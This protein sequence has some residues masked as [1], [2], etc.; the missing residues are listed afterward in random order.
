VSL[1]ADRIP[2][3]ISSYLLLPF[4]LLGPAIV[5]LVFARG[6]EPTP[7]GVGIVA[8]AG[9]LLALREGGAFALLLLAFPFGPKFAFGP[10]NLYLATVLVLASLAWWKLAVI[11]RGGRLRTLP[12]R[13]A[14]PFAVLVG[15][16]V[17]SALANAHDLLASP[18]ALLRLVQFL[19]YLFLL[20]LAFDMAPGGER[21]RFLL[22]LPVLAGVACALDALFLAPPGPGGFLVGT[23]DYQHNHLAAALVLS[24]FLGV[25]LFVGHRAALARIAL[26]CALTFMAAAL[27][28]A[29]SRSGLAG[30]AGGALVLLALPLRRPWRLVLVVGVVAAAAAAFLLAPPEVR[31][32]VTGIAGGDLALTRRLAMWREAGRNFSAHWLFGT[33]AGSLR[34]ADNYFVKVATEL[35]VVGLAAW[36][37]FLGALVAESVRL[38]RAAC[39]AEAGGAFDVVIGLAPATVALLLVMNLTGDFLLV[40]RVMGV[41]WL[42][43]GF[44]LREGEAR[45]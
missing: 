43:F 45:P 16:Y 21:R 29:Q 41:Y 40:H 35:G 22:V 5:A 44:L 10:G 34:L 7:V 31:E 19:A 37:W 12:A 17:L 14:W 36:L 18:G 20:P 2:V 11:A 25:G 30:A 23:F 32:R 39:R 9:L 3:R 38:G 26:A 27:L 8:V 15:V 13:I 28:L 1:P 42:T 4:A 24:I 6:A 33:G